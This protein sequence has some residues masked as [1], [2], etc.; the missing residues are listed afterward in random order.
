MPP[1]V[2]VTDEDIAEA[3]CILLPLGKRFDD[4]RRVFIRRLDTLDLH[5]VPGSGKTTA[6]LA[7]LVALERHMPFGDG[8]GILAISHTNVAVDQI[9]KRLGAHCA[10]L[11]SY[12]NFVGTIQAFVDRFLAIPYYVHKYGGRPLRIDNDLYSEQANRFSLTSL[13]GF[14]RQEQ[15]SAKYYLNCNDNACTFRF[16]RSGLAD[17]LLKDVKGTSLKITRPRA[18]T[19]W[20]D[21]EKARVASWL[22]AFKRQIM[23]RGFLCYDDAYY[24]ADCLLTEIAGARAI[25]QKRFPLV[26][27]DEMQ[28]MGK[29]Q[30]D[31]LER[32]FFDNGTSTSVYQRVGDKNQGIQSPGDFDEEGSW[33]DRTERLTLRNSHRLPEPIARVVQPFAVHDPSASSICGLSESPIRPHLLVYSDSTVCVIHEYANVLKTL[34][35]QGKVPS[36]DDAVYKA[37]AWNAEWPPDESEH[38]GRRRLIDYCP[39]FSRTGVRPRIDH[40]CIA[41]YL[42]T[43]APSPRASGEVHSSIL[44]LFLKVMRLEDIVSPDKG[45][46]FTAATLRRYLRENHPEFYEAFLLSLHRWTTASLERNPTGVEDNVRATIQGLLALFGKQV[47]GSR[48]FVDNIQTA[49]TG[50]RRDK[51]LVTNTCT[52]DGITVQLSTVHGVKGETHTATLYLESFYHQ[53]GRG[54]KAKSY[55]SQRLASQFLGALLS[56]TEGRRVKQSAKMVYVGFSRPTH[57]LCFALHKDRFDQ[58]LSAVDRSAWEVIMLPVTPDGG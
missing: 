27:V 30:H 14:S 16:G 57:L 1:D 51:A 10:R 50:Q 11:F 17:T 46:S 53:D 47:A 37:V 52:S 41:G 25:I 6:L 15:N 2:E 20:C 32:L 31:L 35:G 58:Y 55:E 23:E 24:L 3:E 19:D 36:G 39:A 44:N 18:K 7:K 13:P 34:I 42:E 26:F 43:P 9:K 49:T 8:T 45:C 29:H 5:A 21:T 48:S 38:E 28:D 4:E 33:N 54:L 40:D 56:G 12:P 22:M